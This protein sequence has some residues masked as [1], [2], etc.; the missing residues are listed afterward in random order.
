MHWLTHLA[1]PG[2][3]QVSHT[4]PAAFRVVVR[5]PVSKGRTATWKTV[6]KAFSCGGNANQEPTVSG[7]GQNATRREDELLAPFLAGGRAFR[8]E[9][10]WAR[11]PVAPLPSLFHIV[12]LRTL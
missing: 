8:S 2:I 1:A 4:I 11:R 5:M 9:K 3:L 7:C 10:S 12:F 6:A